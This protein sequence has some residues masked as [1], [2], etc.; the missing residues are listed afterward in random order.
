MDLHAP[1]G[2]VPKRSR[3]AREGWEDT[4]D[5]LARDEGDGQAEEGD[6]QV[7][8]PGWPPHA[9]D[10]SRGTG[11]RRRGMSPMLSDDPARIKVAP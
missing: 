9:R 4:D 7:G 5:E 6:G 2:D 8:Q 11:V 3:P 1:L 10:R